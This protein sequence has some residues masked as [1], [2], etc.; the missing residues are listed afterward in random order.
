MH[1]RNELP[2][3]PA[4]LIESM[5][6][7]GYS[8]P[9]AIADLIDNSITAGARLVDVS[10]T[11]EGADS[12]ISV[13]D[14]GRG[15][16]EATLV[17]AMRLGSRSPIA[18]RDPHDLGRFGLGLEERSVVTGPEPDGHLPCRDLRHALPQ[19]GSRPRDAKPKVGSP[20]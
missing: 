9:T 6:A 17:E 15:M 14:D 11:W 3:D 8:L 2:P 1:S 12:V 16:D 20:G 19:M 10:F 4:A 7:F 13:T 5:R 18:A